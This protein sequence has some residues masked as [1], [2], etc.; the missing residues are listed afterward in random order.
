MR[1]LVLILLFALL[2]ISQI[3]T[4]VDSDLWCHFKTGEYIVKNL[5]VPTT[6]IFSYTLENRAW[7]DHEWLA[8]ILFYF[9]FA[10]FGWLGINILKAIIISLCFLVLLFFIFSKYKRLIYAALF[11]LLAVLAFGYRSFLRPEVFSYL[12]LCLFFYILESERRFYIVPLLQILWVNLHGYFILGPILVFLYCMGELISGDLTRSKRLGALFIVT[13]LACFINPY[14]YKGAVY[15]VE[16]LINIFNQQK[17]Y[18][19]NIYELTMPINVGLGRYL[20][21]WI[22]AVL[23]SVTF[24]INL[25]KAKMRHVLIFLGAFTA[26]Y[27]AIR[28]MPI[29][30]F[31]AMPLAV[32]NLNESKSTR[33]INE[34]KYYIALVFIIL[35][36]V[37]FFISNKY[38]EFTK[39][40]AF[41][42][43]E[44]KM[45]GLLTPSKACDFLEKNNIN[46]RMFNSIDYGHYI[47]YRFY[48]EK[49]VFID[50]RTELYTYD[51]Y[52]SHQRA[53]NY[54]GEWKDL[55]KRYDFD[56]AFLRHLFSGTER[57]VKYLYNSKEWALVYYDESSVVFLRDTPE[58]KAAIEKF[59]IGFSDKKIGKSEEVLSVANFFEKI[60]EVRLAEQV[61][62]K[63]LEANPKF[64]EPANNLVAIYINSGRFDQ[65]LEV[66]DKF[67]QYY[68][69]SAELYCNK[70][71]V[72]LRMGKKEEG[73]L[74][75][76]KSAKLNPY[77][78]QASYMLGLVYYEKG[79][80][81]KATRQFIKY[82]ALD[83]YNAGAHKILGDIYKQKRFFKKAE[84]EYNEADRLEGR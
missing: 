6:D 74:M 9:V 79:Y 39:Q 52:Q 24:L 1:L 31:V 66:L 38:Y 42:K 57:L 77:L 18:L 68:P 14:F 43:T 49:R 16:I 64:L 72:Y 55:Q 37:Y 21:F 29:F 83:P 41:R 35:A 45:M 51:F 50:A 23:S 10:K 33:N 2:A 56:I 19:Q 71:I 15:P 3:N 67:L 62:D 48:P 47:A 12:L 80:P 5:T 76:E 81:D 54:P 17:A 28:N 73:L 82:L 69:E 4:V 78:R 60:G 40:S 84:S 32:I 22:F 65:A 75:L 58:N 20:F 44:S 34:R 61:Y 59:R 70:G 30:V 7:V 27:A 63:L 11:T 13:C 8:Q 53:Q 36:A 26:S 46:G 25:R